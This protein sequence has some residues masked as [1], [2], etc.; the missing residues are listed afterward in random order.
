MGVGATGHVTVPELSRALV[1]GAGTTRHMAAP[2]LL[3]ARRREPWDM[4]SCVH[5]LS[6]IFDL[7]LIHG[8]PGLQ[9][10]NKEV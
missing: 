9:G 2:E 4:R 7:K 10:T 6:F 1:A 3:C 8:V 5:V